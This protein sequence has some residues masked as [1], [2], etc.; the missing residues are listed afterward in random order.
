MPVNELQ[1]LL[2]VAGVKLPNGSLLQGGQ[3]TTDLSIVGPPDNLVIT[4]PFEIDNTR[5]AGFNLGSKLKGIAGAAMG[6]SGNV[7]DI[8]AVRAKLQVANSGIRA[9]AIYASMPALGEATGQGTVSP[10]GALNFRLMMKVNTSSGVGGVAVG[11]L[12]AFSGAGATTAR[13]AA[14][15]GVPVT[16]TGTSSDPVITPDVN[17]LLR[18]NATSIL[19]NQKNGGQQVLRTLGG[20]FGKK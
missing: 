6:Q 20:L 5:L 14:A 8:R 1:T 2:P 7:T 10:A 16:I 4:G 11:L 3:L 12:S 18:N 9:D 13:Q 17:G 19:G 15:N